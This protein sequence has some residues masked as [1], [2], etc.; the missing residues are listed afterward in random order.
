MFFS[1]GKLCKTA[2]IAGST[3]GNPFATYKSFISDLILASNLNSPG[4]ELEGGAP[5]S[6]ELG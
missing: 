2:S 1:K 4:M 3:G 6:E 5:S